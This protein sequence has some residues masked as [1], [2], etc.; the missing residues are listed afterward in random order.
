MDIKMLLTEQDYENASRFYKTLGIAEITKRLE[1][2]QSKVN[3][4]YRKYLLAKAHGQMLTEEEESQQ[5]HDSVDCELIMEA[6]KEAIANFLP[7]MNMLVGMS[8]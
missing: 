4:N 6:R 8:A 7:P 3:G 2:A 5:E 1:R